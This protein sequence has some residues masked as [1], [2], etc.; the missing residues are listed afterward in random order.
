[1]GASKRTTGPI[2]L[3]K[4]YY[5]PG[6]TTADSHHSLEEVAALQPGLCRCPNC[7]RWYQLDGDGL[8]IDLGPV[9]EKIRLRDDLVSAI[10]Q[11]TVAG[12]SIA[13]LTDKLTTNVTTLWLVFLGKL[14]AMTQQLE[15]RAHFLHGEL[16]K[17]AMAQGDLEPLVTTAKQIIDIVAALPDGVPTKV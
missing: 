8:P 14:G 7:H 17:R 16:A 1:M 11:T 13:R 10:S 9:L 3:A 6:C 12:E 5:C 15:S 2:D 4:M